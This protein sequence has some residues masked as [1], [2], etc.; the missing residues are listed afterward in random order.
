MIIDYI[1][2]IL[3]AAISMFGWWL[4]SAGSLIFGL[5]TVLF[6]RSND[7]MEKMHSMFMAYHYGTSIILLGV[8]IA[9]SSSLG[10]FIK[11]LMVVSLN[12]V[13]SFSIVHS[14]TKRIYVDNVKINMRHR[15]KEEQFLSNNK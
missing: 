12:V 11:G 2:S 7:V 9:T 5:N 14:L 10:E 4:C 1:L 13:T 6:C 8:F 15:K 3:Y